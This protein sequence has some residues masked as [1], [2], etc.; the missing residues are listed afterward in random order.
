MSQVLCLCAPALWSSGAAEGGICRRILL[1]LHVGSCLGWNEGADKIIDLSCSDCSVDKGN[2][3]FFNDNLSETSNWSLK[4]HKALLD[5]FEQENTVHAI[6]KAGEG[7]SLNDLIGCNTLWLPS[8]ETE[9]WCPPIIP[10]FSV[11][12]SR[13]TALRECTL[14]LTFSDV[15]PFF[16]KVFLLMQQQPCS[17]LSW[18]RQ[19][20]F[21][22]AF[23][24]RRW[25]SR[26]L[27]ECFGEDI[28]VVEA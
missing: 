2:T 10:L 6:S 21:C 8:A 14:T 12:K 1:H 4:H 9:M 26:Q 11:A 19:S 22:D 17:G 18:H 23:V 16:A 27:D 15:H 3:F 5:I 7:D 24:T 20:G 28:F 25:T 13:L